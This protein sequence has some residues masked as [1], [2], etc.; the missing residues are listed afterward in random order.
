MHDSTFIF[1]LTVFTH[2]CYQSFHCLCAHNSGDRIVVVLPQPATKYCTS[3]GSHMLCLGEKGRRI[4][5]EK[6][7]VEG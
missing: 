2:M 4:R 7:K 5:K 6:I 1:C 3:T